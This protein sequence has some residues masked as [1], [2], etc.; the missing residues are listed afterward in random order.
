MTTQDELV[1][2][3]LTITSH[4]NPTIQCS[5]ISNSYDDKPQ[6]RITIT[7]DIINQNETS[8]D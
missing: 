8:T 3:I 1:Q 2:S 4:L 6:K 7:Y 5:T